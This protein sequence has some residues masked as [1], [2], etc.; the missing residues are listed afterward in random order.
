MTV[1]IIEKTKTIK[2]GKKPV[3]IVPLE[4]WSEFEDYLEDREALASRG[5]LG[6]IARARG[7]IKTK[8]LLRP[9]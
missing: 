9:W 7:D 8:R 2:V 3:V 6:R 5:F 4:L 1:E